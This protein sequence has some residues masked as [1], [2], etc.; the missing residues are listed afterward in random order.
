MQASLRLRKISAEIRKCKKCRLYKHARKA[1]PGE[2]PAN[3]KV[4][5]VGQ[6]PGVA[7]DRTGRPFVGRS[8]KFLD[9]LLRSAGLKRQQV[10]IT[11]VIKHFPPRNRTPKKDEIKACK[12]YI[13]Q[14]LKLVNPKIVVLMGKVAQNTLRNEPVLKGKKVIKTAHPAAGRRFP[15]IG[16]K[17]EKDFA[18][19]KK[20]VQTVK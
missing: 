4:F 14:Q 17:M 6:A 2:G 12:P 1:V 19:L 7:E 9:K 15:K 13:L 20:L 8:G 11:S 16:K 5:F 10:F 18:K 3:A